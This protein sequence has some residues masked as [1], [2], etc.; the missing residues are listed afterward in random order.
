[1]TQCAISKPKSKDEEKAISGL[2]NW[3]R[4]H[5]TCK[6]RQQ[7]TADRHGWAC[8]TGRGCRE[9]LPCHVG[10]HKLIYCSQQWYTQGIMDTWPHRQA[11]ASFWS[12]TTLYQQKFN[13]H[14]ICFPVTPEQKIL[15]KQLLNGSTRNMSTN[16]VMNSWISDIVGEQARCMVI[17][18]SKQSGDFGDIATLTSPRQPLIGH[19]SIQAKIEY[20]IQFSF[21]NELSE[22]PSKENCW[23]VQQKLWQKTNIE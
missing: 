20:G 2:D 10:T 15:D 19:K 4:R 9:R 14:I 12:S 23:T 11:H 16:W 1:M 3:A 21:W 5:W 7:A 22:K 6:Q 17:C 8:E 18:L 13:I